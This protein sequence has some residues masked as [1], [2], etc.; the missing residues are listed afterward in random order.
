VLPVGGESG[1]WLNRHFPLNPISALGKDI[2]FIS[3]GQEFDR[4]PLSN[5]KGGRNVQGGGS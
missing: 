3:I 4:N 5:V 1:E 2:D